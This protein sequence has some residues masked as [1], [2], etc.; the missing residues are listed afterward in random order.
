MNSCPCLGRYTTQN[1]T[2][3]KQQQNDNNI[4]LHS[5]PE[6]ICQGNV[7]QLLLSVR[8]IISEEEENTNKKVIVPQ[9]VWGG[10]KGRF[11]ALWGLFRQAVPMSSPLLVV[12]ICRLNPG[13]SLHVANE[14]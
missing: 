10:G 2:N 6:A 11:E 9:G 1:I 7:F 5:I 3:N 12:H 13:L 8:E 4:P 14:N